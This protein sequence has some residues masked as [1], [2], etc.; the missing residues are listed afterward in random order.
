MYDVSANGRK[1]LS[2]GSRTLS[3]PATAL[4]RDFSDRPEPRFRTK[5]SLAGSRPST[6]RATISR[7]RTGHDRSIGCPRPPTGVD[8]GGTA[9]P[10]CVHLGLSSPAAVFVGAACDLPSYFSADF[11]HDCIDSTA[12]D[13]ASSTEIMCGVGKLRAHKLRRSVEQLDEAQEQAVGEFGSRAVDGRPLDDEL[14]EELR[15]VKIQQL[16][17]GVV[18]SEPRHSS[19]AFS[20]SLQ[21]PLTPCFTINLPTHCGIARPC[22]GDDSDSEER[23]PFPNDIGVGCEVEGATEFRSNKCAAEDQHVLGRL[24]TIGLAPESRL[25]SAATDWSAPA[26]PCFGVTPT[27]PVR[28][29]QAAHGVPFP[30]PAANSLPPAGLVRGGQHSSCQVPSI[31]CPNASCTPPVLR[32]EG[33]AETAA[34]ILKL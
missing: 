16:L 29:Q 33:L 24:G 20:P 26:D 15:V 30:P 21:H 1:T 6:A 7:P 22:S 27:A 34:D 12:S 23:P 11:H 2:S 5:F 18:A 28:C 32:D 4:P 10:T 25:S 14:M 8:L 19:P 9:P 13:L 17:A 3:Y 31:L